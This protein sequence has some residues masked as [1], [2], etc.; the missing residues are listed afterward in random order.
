MIVTN[1]SIAVPSN[2]TQGRD[3]TISVVTQAEVFDALAGEWD[4]LLERCD[5]SIYQTFAWQ[6]LW[7]KNFGEGTSRLHIIVLRR[8]KRVVG[9][10]PFFISTTHTLGLLPL[11]KLTFIGQGPSDYL[12]VLFARGE[13]KSCATCTAEYLASQHSL[14]DIIHLEDFSDRLPNHTLL[15]EALQKKGFRGDHFINEYCPRTQLKEDWEATLTSF[16]IDT[17][18]EIR[19]RARNIQ[20]TFSVEFELVTEETAAAEAV[21]AFIQLHQHKWTNTGHAGEFADPRCVRFHHEL[22]VEFARR[23]WLSLA[24]LRVNG[25]RVATLYCFMFRNDLAVYLTGNSNRSDVYKFSPGRVLTA[26]CMEQAVAQ[27]KT[28]CDFMRGNEPYKYEMDAVDV[29]NW[30]MLLYNPRSLK[31]EFR[32]R[33]ELLTKS[34]KRRTTHERLLYQVVAREHGLFSSA[35]RE[36]LK[37][38]AKKNLADGATKAKAPER[39][40]HIHTK[41]AEQRTDQSDNQ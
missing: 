10:A 20:K 6:R 36:H 15:F 23:G 9:I 38:R 25:E 5:A 21:D 14:F 34:L 11:R 41:S 18:R 40:T 27:G 39:A 13:E 17:R 12:D 19:R 32:Y 2:V 7:W 33:I 8:G 37:S 28:V 31:P 29:P 24:F 26:Y 1:D 35:M 22:V 16:K 3:I 30:A 4:K